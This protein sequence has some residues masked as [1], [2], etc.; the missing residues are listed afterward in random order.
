MSTPTFDYSGERQRR[1]AAALIPF[2]PGTSPVRADTGWRN[3]L[4]LLNTAEFKAESLFIRRVENRVF[5]R[6]VNLARVDGATTAPNGAVILTLPGGFQVDNKDPSFF[7][8]IFLQGAS[9]SG[10]AYWN[11]WTDSTAIKAASVM[12]TWSITHSFNGGINYLTNTP[13][14][15]TLPG[16]A[17]A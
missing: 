3:V 6:W 4:S 15:A 9:N 7:S 14:P 13:W 1:A 2:L 11:Y 5:V 10:S 16:V 17:A 12:G 8:R